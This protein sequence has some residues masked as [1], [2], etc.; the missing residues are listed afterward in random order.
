V[1]AAIDKGG[2]REGNLGSQPMPAPEGVPTVL[3]ALVAIVV[4]IVAILGYAATRPDTFRIERSIVIGAPPQRIQPLIADFRRWAAWSPFEAI[5]PTMTRTFGGAESGVGATYAWAG[6]GKA[7]VGRMEI[8]E[9]ADQ[10]VV[11]KLDFSK[12]FEAHNI[13]EFTLVPEGAG[14]RVTWAMH[15]PSPFLAKVMTSFISMDSMVGKD[16]ATGLASLK[17]EAER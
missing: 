17:V 9:A 7:G 1:T 14:T 2:S 16:F 11:I 15:G 3:Y 6:N 12:P 8:L 13:A 5:D 10:Q 4:L